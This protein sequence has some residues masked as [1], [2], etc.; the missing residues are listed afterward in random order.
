MPMIPRIVHP[1]H[2]GLGLGF[3]RGGGWER[4]RFDLDFGIGFGWYQGGV[5]RSRDSVAASTA[6]RVNGS[7]WYLPADHSAK[8]SL[9]C[10]LAGF[11]DCPPVWVPTDASRSDRSMI[12]RHDDT[13]TAS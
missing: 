12:W 9:K 8:R 10:G 11:P 7:G 6:A 3:F 1:Y 5:S 2:R 4:R 13:T